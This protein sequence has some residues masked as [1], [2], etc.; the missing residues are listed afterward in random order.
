MCLPPG[1]HHNFFAF[2]DRERK[3]LLAMNEYLD[4]L[5]L[6]R[7][8]WMSRTSLQKSDTVRDQGQRKG[9]LEIS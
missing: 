5:V 3:L 1:L 8:L 6:A 4:Y 9:F 2:A 7:R